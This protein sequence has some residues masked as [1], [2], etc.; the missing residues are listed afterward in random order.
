MADNVDLA[1]IVFELY[2]QGRVEELQR[3]LHPDAVVVPMVSPEAE[4]HGRSEVGDFI[5]DETGRRW[6]YEV[7]GDRFTAV[8]DRWVIVEGRLRFSNPEPNGGF[9]DRSS[10]W[11]TEFDDGLLIRSEPVVSAEEAQRAVSE[12]AGTR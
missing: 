1:R 3:Y 11:L 9:R 5:S 7:R 2:S 8:G 12:R 6:L 4:L 10:I